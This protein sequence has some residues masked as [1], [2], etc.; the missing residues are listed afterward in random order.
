M[1]VTNGLICAFISL[2]SWI[3]SVIGVLN[4]VLELAVLAG[5]LV[6]MYFTVRYLI[7]K[8]KKL[9]HTTPKDSSDG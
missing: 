6:V 8:T 7:R 1:T 2:V 5:N 3:T 9:D 4:H